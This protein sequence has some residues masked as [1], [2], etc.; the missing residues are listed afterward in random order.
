MLCLRIMARLI[1]AASQQTIESLTTDE[2]YKSL[3]QKALNAL[4]SFNEYEALDFLFW[5]RKFRVAKIPLNFPASALDNFHKRITEFLKN[6]SFNF[7]NLVNLYYDYSFLNKN[8]DDIC[9]EIARELRTDIKLLTP[10]SV[11]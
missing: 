11:I 9:S 4:D 7:R 6:K 3:T 10:F 5:M 8:C 1:R 2:R